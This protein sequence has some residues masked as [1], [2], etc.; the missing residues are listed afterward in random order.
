M[1]LVKP[2]PRCDFSSG[3]ST[4]EKT[5]QTWITENQWSQLP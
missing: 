4:N 3:E 1:E 5:I 2:E